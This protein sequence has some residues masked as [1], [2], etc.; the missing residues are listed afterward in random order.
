MAI[1]KVGMSPNCTRL[2]HLQELP[3]KGNQTELSAMYYWKSTNLFFSSVLLLNS[4]R[5]NGHIMNDDVIHGNESY[6]DYCG[7]YSD[8][9]HNDSGWWHQTQLV[10]PLVDQH[11]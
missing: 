8:Y 4:L 6:D 3:F 2:G 7:Y 5:H 11:K 10:F 9:D 1:N